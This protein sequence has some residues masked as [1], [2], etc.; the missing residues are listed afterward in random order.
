MAFRPKVYDVIRIDNRVL[1]FNEHP[2]AKGMPYGQ[3]GR[4]ATVY[5]VQDS[6]GSLYALKVFNLA[7][8]SPLIEE[9]SRQISRFQTIA[10][11][12]AC[13]RDVL[14]PQTYANLIQE[15]P[16]LS[17][18]VVMPWVQGSNWQEIILGRKPI[19]PEVS[20]VLATSFIHLMALL[21]QKGVAHCDLS[22]PNLI[23]YLNRKNSSIPVSLIDLEDLHAPGLI[24]PQKLPAGSAGYAH[25]QARNGVW[26]AEADRFAGAILIAEML[27]WCDERVRRIAYGEQYFDP[28]EMQTTCER[29][30]VLLQV[31]R[32]RWGAMI[33]TVFSQAW[34]AP[35]LDA[36][37]TFANW[38]RA[39]D[40]PPDP[41]EIRAQIARLERIGRWNDVLQAC[42]ELLKLDSTQTEIWSIR[43][44]AQ[45]LQ[46]TDAEISKAWN[47]AAE[48]GQ[49][50]DWEAC[51]KLITAAE[52][53][54]PDVVKYQAQREQAEKELD[55]ALRLDQ[56]EDYINARQWTEAEQ[57][58]QGVTHV[59]PRYASL[60]V[61]LDEVAR[62]EKE[63]SQNRLVAKQ[64]LERE[65]WQTA[66][67]AISAI[68]RVQPLG[69]DLLA[70][71]SQ[72]EDLETKLK[73]LERKAKDLQN[74]LTKAKEHFNVG[75]YDLAEDCVNAILGDFPKNP[76]AL[77]LLTDIT[78]CKAHK[79]ALQ[80]AIELYQDGNLELAA[81]I[82]DTIPQ[83]F[84]NS[85]HL[86]EQVNQRLSWRN[87]LEHERQL[88]HP[89]EVLNILRWRPKDEAEHPD[90]EKWATE[91]VALQKEI[92]EAYRRGELSKLVLLL[93]NAP[94]DYPN[95]TFL[96]DQT[97]HRLEIQ[98]LIQIGLAAYD[99]DLINDVL[100]ELPPN[101]KKYPELVQWKRQEE[102]LRAQI[103]Q[104][105]KETNLI[106]GRQLLDKVPEDHPLRANFQEWLEREEKI[107]NQILTALEQYDVKSLELIVNSLPENHPLKNS[108]QKRLN[109]EKERQQTLIQAQKVY[110]GETILRVLSEVEEDYPNYLE[111][112]NWAEAELDRQN[113]IRQVLLDG[114]AEKIEELIKGLPKNHPYAS[115][116][117]EWLENERKNQSEKEK[118]QAATF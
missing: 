107:Q 108:S 106:A 111:L 118:R 76:Q 40:P 88:W 15:Y 44:R 58:L 89:D 29:Y 101:D 62:L 86:R 19:D 42:D 54:G 55:T 5:Q 41:M 67:S 36:C 18:A 91:M 82:L 12:E 14:T 104:A 8:R 28:S 100:E 37:P 3:T 65:D 33:A 17:Y 117:Q 73:E 56:A 74:K 69:P 96:L 26:S 79:R 32:E 11:L 90:L 64:A 34:F 113:C 24:P 95:R 57:F 83:D 115:E 98:Q 59:Q 22:G 16:D 21:E 87:Q 53:L 109:A 52:L 116:L 93:D 80:K 31:L 25:P 30:Q 43:A 27:S 6:H 114:E 4:R 38:V 9:Q 7:F 102:N 13:K 97:Q 112:K 110:D 1:R 105:Y 61:K 92:D 94:A 10:G 99:L 75:E 48:S 45:Q 66:L 77:Q 72:A 78:T 35:T 50:E 2:S 47:I 23:I 46:K 60:R 49:T 68:E 63:V 103:N 20:K 71:K 84:E 81:E 51:L 85:V 39:I 70:M